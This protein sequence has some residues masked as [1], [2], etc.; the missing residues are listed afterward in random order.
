ML[1]Y[2]VRLMSQFREAGSFDLLH[3]ILILFYY[4]CVSLCDS[5]GNARARAFHVIMPHVLHLD[6]DVQFSVLI[7]NLV[8]G[9]AKDFTGG[10]KAWK[11]MENMEND[12]G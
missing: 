7:P 10:E 5:S 4:E 8:V 11:V 2:V 3:Q 1:D 12:C 9:A 6:L